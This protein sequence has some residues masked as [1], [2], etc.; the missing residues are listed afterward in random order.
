MRREQRTR[1]TCTVGPVTAV[2]ATLAWS[3][4]RGCYPDNINTNDHQWGWCDVSNSR[5][6]NPNLD[7]DVSWLLMLCGG[8]LQHGNDF[9]PVALCPLTPILYVLCSTSAI[10]QI[11]FMVTGRCIAIF[12]NIFTT[13]L[14]D[15]HHLMLR[16]VCSSTIFFQEWNQNLPNFPA[17][18]NKYLYVECVYHLTE[19]VISYNQSLYIRINKIYSHES[20]FA[21]LWIL[22]LR[23]VHSN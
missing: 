5:T 12:S 11:W 10:H 6:Q 7:K 3:P 21:R 22:Y 8:Q 4:N 16:K 20:I 14:L 19:F 23:D 1:T 18:I 9:I 15:F 13:C 17:C 2:G